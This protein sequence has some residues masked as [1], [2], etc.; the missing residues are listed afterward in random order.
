MRVQESRQ[1]CRERARKYD[2]KAERVERME[3]DS[4]T[5]GRQAGRDD[6]DRLEVK[7]R[8]HS[9]RDKG[10]EVNRCWERTREG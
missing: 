5:V 1:A 3:K 6:K 10:K 2:R 9:K 4:C 8:E 7:E